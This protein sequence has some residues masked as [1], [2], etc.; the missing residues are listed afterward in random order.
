MQLIRHQRTMLFMWCLVFFAITG[1]DGLFGN[2]GEYA[3][4]I[5]CDDGDQECHGQCIPD[6]QLC[7]DTNQHL[8]GSQCIPE[9]QSCCDEDGAPFGGG[10]GT[11]DA[12]YRICTESHFRNIASEKALD[13]HYRMHS[14]ISFSGSI[15]PI[16]ALGPDEIELD[17]AVSEESGEVEI[18]I[19]HDDPFQGTFDGNGY[20]LQSPIISSSGNPRTGTAIFGHLGQQAK[21]SD[22]T[23]NAVSFSSNLFSGGLV[24][25]NEGEITDVTLHGTIDEVAGFGAFMGGL[26]GVNADEGVITNCEVE[27]DLRGTSFLGGLVGVNYGEIENC[28]ASGDL[29]AELNDSLVEQEV[30]HEDTPL[31]AGGLA[32]MNYGPITSSGTTGSVT[33]DVDVDQFEVVVVAAGGFV[34][35]NGADANVS[36]SFSAA[37]LVGD[38]ELPLTS[39]SPVYLGGLAGISHGEIAN[40]YATGDITF[41]SAG[42]NAAA[43]GG[44]VGILAP[45]EVSFGL[46]SNSYAS[47]FIDSSWL[48]ALSGGAYGGLVGENHYSTIVG[49]YWDTETSE[50]EDSDGGTGLSTSDFA[51][52]DSFGNW[53]FD[54]GGTWKMGVA[55]DGPPRPVL[56][57]QDR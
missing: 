30:S 31:F 15:E 44:L 54:D 36:K 49:S 42:F 13:A 40:C 53:N 55:P 39:D 20:A 50:V 6:D 47:G 48:G 45:T 51:N 2:L 19:H 41:E 52:E 4:Q 38:I 25:Y 33:I 5:P 23:V 12:P 35:A 21:I 26:V 56:Q 14:D 18:L 10:E 22:L 7:C 29:A 57:W 11:S 27:V 3:F 37:N 17:E 9:D 16:A 46:I 24:G 32:A 8:C 28:I 43:L 1:C 34:G